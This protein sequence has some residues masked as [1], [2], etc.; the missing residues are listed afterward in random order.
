MKIVM[1]HFRDISGVSGGLERLLC[2][3]SNEMSKR[4][5]DVHILTYDTSETGIPYFPLE[6][7]VKVHNLRR[8]GKEPIKVPFFKKIS[9]EW[10]R[11]K[12]EPSLAAWYE[13]Y[14]DP[15][16]LPDARKFFDEI[17][18]D[19][20]IVY[21]YTTSGFVKETHGNIPVIT[22]FHNI[23]DF[24][25]P[26]MS[27]RE[28]QGI[29]ESN[30][31]QCLTPNFVPM[32][33]KRIP[34]G[35]IVCIPNSV[36]QSDRTANLA[37]EKEI[38]KILY[39]ARLN[40]DVKRQHLLIDAFAKIAKDFPN[41]QLF[42]WGDGREDYKDLLNKKVKDF[43]LEDRIHLCGITH[44]VTKEYLDSDLIA[45]PSHHEGFALS[46]AEGMSCGLPVVAYRS[47]S[48]VN[49]IV[50]NGKDG[51]LVDDGIDP[52]AE[53]MAKLMDNRELRI[54]MGKAAH[55]AMKVYSPE[56]VWDT[57]E[58][59]LTNTIKQTRSEA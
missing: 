42:F 6:K 11:S 21:F 46:M 55:E 57:W 52:L 3:F 2:N 1:A 58:T 53:G 20:I 13:A 38:Y 28:F 50:E 40:K 49:E 15:Y 19:V 25:F 17:H 54:S 30:V 7:N 31:I 4:G 47:C 29:S 39:V 35:N 36:P 22:M 56:K 26:K 37:V 32:I 48:A 33:R 14:R 43:G 12:G 51:L 44:D 34:D 9:R 27:T 45:F 8:K 23:P 41:W 5:Y 16:I 59:L 18:P 10:A 24:L